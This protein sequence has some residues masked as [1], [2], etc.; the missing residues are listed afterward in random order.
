MMVSLEIT[1]MLG[2]LIMHPVEKYQPAGHYELD[3]DCSKLPAGNY[4]YKLS[5]GNTIQV[6]KLVIIK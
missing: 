1:D 5:A 2:M 6:K 3:I 4:L